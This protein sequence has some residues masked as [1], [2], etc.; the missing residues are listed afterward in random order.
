MTPPRVKICGITNG[1]DAMAACDAGADALGF[2]FHGSS[3][4]SVER[5][6]VA[7]IVRFLPPYVTT[8][9]V[10]VRPELDEVEETVDFCGLDRAQIHGVTDPEFF[11]G[12]GIPTIVALAVKDSSSL[13]DIEQ[14]SAKAVLLDAYDP[15]LYGGTGKT[16]DWS[17]A[18][19]LGTLY[20]GSVPIVIAG[21]LTPENVGEAISRVRPHAV[22][23]SSG[24]EAEPGRKDPERMRA[25]VRAVKDHG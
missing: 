16:F 7:H 18:E 19:G 15:N 21:G 12:L 2:V 13:K 8:V 11:R 22:D 10:F 3:P 9:G 4:R 17:L 25:F 20:Q 5:A 14:Y 24:V 23:V 1:V 6:E